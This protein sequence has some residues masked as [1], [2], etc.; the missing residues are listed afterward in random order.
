MGL[1]AVVTLMALSE[2]SPAELDRAFSAHEFIVSE[3][4]RRVVIPYRLLSPQKIEPGQRYP[5]VVFLHGG[6]ERGSDNRLQLLYFPEL[7]AQPEHRLRYPCFLVAAQCRE[8][9]R[10][11]EVA[12]EDV[13]STPLAD[14]PTPE[15]QAVMGIVDELSRKLPIDERRIYLT[16]I[17]M[18]GYGAWELALREPQR[19]AKLVPICGGGDERL[20]A[21]LVNMP[22]WAWHGA[23]DEAVPVVRSRRMIEAIREAGGRPRYTELPNVAHNAWTPAYRDPALL[24][25]MF[26]RAEHHASRIAGAVAMLLLLGIA[27]AGQLMKLVRR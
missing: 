21:R 4:A 7:M 24:D 12:W 2:L 10:W 3:G 5:L 17:S 27:A 20:A 25:W 6:G 23:L 11:V 19:F 26:D 22:T 15:L 8:N 14:E 18:G 13:E 16:G 1:A 9:H